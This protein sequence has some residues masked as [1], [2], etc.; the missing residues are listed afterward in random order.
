MLNHKNKS[1]QPEEI[2]ILPTHEE[3]RAIKQETFMQMLFNHL[4]FIAECGLPC[5]FADQVES[6]SDMYYN[7]S[8]E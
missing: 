2:K 7:L 3:E 8:K 5:N 1:V 4:R 6:M